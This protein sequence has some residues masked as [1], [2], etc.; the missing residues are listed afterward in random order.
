MYKTLGKAA[1]LHLYPDEPR[2]RLFT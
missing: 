1:K 2:T